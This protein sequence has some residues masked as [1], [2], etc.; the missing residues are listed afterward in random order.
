MNLHDKRVI[1]VPMARIV[2]DDLVEFAE[3]QAL[4]LR[5]GMGSDWPIAMIRYLLKSFQES[6]EVPVSS[7]R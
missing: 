2:F 1:E 4:A 3:L 5:L 7:A 6:S